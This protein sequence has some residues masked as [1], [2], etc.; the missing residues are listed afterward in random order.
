MDLS[1]EKRNAS[2]VVGS[3]YSVGDW[4]MVC[5]KTMIRVSRGIM[6]PVES[7]RPEGLVTMRG[8]LTFIGIL[9]SKRS[10]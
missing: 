9:I 6:W 4:L 1:F 8:M 10:N 7:F 2:N 5:D 3:G